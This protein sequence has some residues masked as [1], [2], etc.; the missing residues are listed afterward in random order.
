MFL[1]A[2]RLVDRP[3]ILPHD[4]AAEQ[5][6]AAALRALLLDAVQPL[7]LV[8][9]AAGR[10][11]RSFN[12]GRSRRRGALHQYAAHAVAFSAESRTRNETANQGHD[13]KTHGKVPS[14]HIDPRQHI[15]M[16]TFIAI[17]Q[18]AE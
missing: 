16:L 3:L 1:P 15:R 7:A 13:R 12:N 17:L 11:S 18:R 6:I 14:R 8:A 2:N 10:R 4:L 9:S 5:P